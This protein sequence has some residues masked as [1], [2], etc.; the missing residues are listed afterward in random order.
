[1]YRKI[2]VPVDGAEPAWQALQHALQLGACLGASLTVVHVAPSA[3]AAA[4]HGPWEAVLALAKDKVAAYPYPVK[5]LLERGHP[6]VRLLALAAAGHHDLIVMG[7][8][9]LSDVAEFFLGS[10]STDILH[11]SPIPVLLIR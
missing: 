11:K 2:L 9:G 8:R 10:V 6:S 4:P 5:V 1:M 3:H 7:N